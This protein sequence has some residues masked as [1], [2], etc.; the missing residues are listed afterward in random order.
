MEYY[1]FIIKKLI[2]DMFRKADVYFKDHKVT[3]NQNIWGGEELE[4]EH[5]PVIDYSEMRE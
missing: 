3:T 1:I 4:V 2:I 5:I